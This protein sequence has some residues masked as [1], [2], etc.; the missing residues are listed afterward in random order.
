[1]LDKQ[2]QVYVR[3][4]CCA[5]RGWS[6]QC[7]ADPEIQRARALD[8]VELDM[9]INRLRKLRLPWSAGTE[10]YLRQC[11]VRCPCMMDGQ[12]DT[13]VEYLTR[14]YQRAV[15][16]PKMN[17]GTL[18]TT[19]VIERLTQA[20]L[21]RF[22]STG[23]TGGG[24]GI[25]Q[26][27]A[28]LDTLLHPQ[29]STRRAQMVVHLCAD[30]VDVQSARSV[31]EHVRGRVMAINLRTFVTNRGEVVRLATDSAPVK[32][33]EGVEHAIRIALD[34]DTVVWHN[35]DMERC[36]QALTA[37]ATYGDL[38]VAAV[39]EC[40]QPVL[41]VGSKRV[42]ALLHA[43]HPVEDP[44]R[45]PLP[46]A[47][48]LLRETWPAVADMFCAESC[49]VHGTMRVPALSKTAMDEVLQWW[50][51]SSSADGEAEQTRILRESRRKRRSH[52]DSAVTRRRRGVRKWVV[53]SAET[54]RQPEELPANVPM[55]TGIIQLVDWLLLALHQTATMDGRGPDE[56]AESWQA[57]MQCPVEQ[58]LHAA[59]AGEDN[60]VVLCSLVHHTVQVIQSLPAMSS[61]NETLGWLYNACVWHLRGRSLANAY[62]QHWLLPQLL[63]TPLGGISGVTGMTLHWDRQRDEWYISTEGSN[64]VSLYTTNNGLAIDRHRCFTTS[65]PEILSTLGL[66]AVCAMFSGGDLAQSLKVNNASC[67]LLPWVQLVLTNCIQSVVDHLSSRGQ[68][69]GI[70]R[71]S[72]I[73]NSAVLAS[74]THREQLDDDLL[75]PDGSGRPNQ[76]HSPR[77]GHGD[78]RLPVWKFSH[79]VDR[80]SHHVWDERDDSPCGLVTIPVSH[81][82]LRLKAQGWF[83]GTKSASCNDCHRM[84][85]CIFRPL[86]ICVQC[87]PVARACVPQSHRLPV[88][89]ASVF[90][91]CA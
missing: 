64:F 43:E 29:Q 49:S 80:G 17:I 22:H 52:S 13:L 89:C 65:V 20:R 88:H 67:K 69:R 84:C 51:Q 79:C 11:L 2:S 59:L 86:L 27:S 47:A 25:Q 90:L 54:Q 36:V 37:G 74:I 16:P 85:C 82:T 72:I 15:L 30:V 39:W 61:R 77:R 42:E 55:P 56:P 44:C 66:E 9:V 14:L 78:H 23:T 1:M 18:D 63:V 33:M 3:T 60:L 21:S 6:R 10:A 5:W 50:G 68:W 75:S 8:P 38:V 12:I 31:L 19:R 4:V 26:A 62:L 48:D 35:L 76:A 24:A 71:T 91:Q 70:N 83:P 53:P 28:N 87:R 40:N 58:L 41:Y 34:A 32:L 46:D 45:H 81:L 73:V 57:W 7:C